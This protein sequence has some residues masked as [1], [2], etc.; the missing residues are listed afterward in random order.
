M[1]TATSILHTWLAFVYVIGQISESSYALLTA[2]A[3]A[4]KTIE[5]RKDQLIQ[6]G[7]IFDSSLISAHSY[8]FTSVLYCYDKRDNFRTQSCL[9]NELR[10]DRCYS[11]VSEHE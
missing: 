9:A 2:R 5:N 6:N 7:A 8:I 10:P 1:A 3:H 4:D 11:T